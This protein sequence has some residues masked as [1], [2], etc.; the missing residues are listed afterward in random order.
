MK[1]AKYFAVANEQKFLLIFSI[2]AAW[3]VPALIRKADR[4]ERGQMYSAPEVLE[5]TNQCD[6]NDG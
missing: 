3:A 2:V 6:E 4:A 1:I 5:T